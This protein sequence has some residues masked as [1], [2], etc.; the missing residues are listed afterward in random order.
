MSRT[1]EVFGFDELSRLAARCSCGTEITF[2]LMDDP[3]F[4]GSCPSCNRTIEGLAEI[5]K[6]FRD[7]KQKAL[8]AKLEVSF[9]VAVK[10]NRLPLP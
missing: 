5:V 3:R 6:L 7:A 9:P 8:Q 10:T 4:S 1:F 2:D